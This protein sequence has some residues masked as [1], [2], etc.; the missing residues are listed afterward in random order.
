[1]TT[2]ACLSVLREF[3]LSRMGR[4]THEEALVGRAIEKRQNSPPALAE[5]QIAN[6]GER[7][8]HFEN[9]CTQNEY[10]FQNAD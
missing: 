1:M 4:L 5:E 3:L 8:S 7:S 2:A 9:N 10:N 6:T